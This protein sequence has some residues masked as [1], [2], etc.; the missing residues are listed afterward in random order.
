MTAPYTHVVGTK[1]F[2]DGAVRRF[3]GCSV[4]AMV[5]ASSPQAALLTRLQQ[6]AMAARFGPKLVALP[7]SSFHMTVID[8]LCYQVRGP[9]HWSS[10]VE[11]NCPDDQIDRF[12]AHRLGRVPLPSGLNMRF[13]DLG[14]DHTTVHLRLDPAD[15]ATADA[16][17]RYREQASRATGIRHPGH[18]AYRFHISLAYWRRAL[19]DDERAEQSDLVDRWQTWLARD[20]GTLRLGP[21]HLAL[22]ED[23]FAFP[24]RRPS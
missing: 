15:A 22:F 19:R 3:P 9:E 10:A 17:G 6:E 2:A 14:P 4:V 18:D 12:V 16:L 11:V 7:P 24:S 13:S 5:P 1:F 8:L 21:P 20:F 23:M